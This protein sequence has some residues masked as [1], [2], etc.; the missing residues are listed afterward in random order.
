MHDNNGLWLSA[1]EY[2][3]IVSEINSNYD[4]YNGKMF[5]AHISVGIDNNYYIYYFVN[6]GFDDYTIVKRI[7]Y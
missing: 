7:K 4:F 5:A 2:K 3:K 6:R 1:E